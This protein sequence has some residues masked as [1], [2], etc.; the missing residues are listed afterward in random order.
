MGEA[1]RDLGWP[2]VGRNYCKFYIFFSFMI[3]FYLETI[4][5]SLALPN[6]SQKLE[7]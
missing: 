7:N 6:C 2:R 5:V 3:F 1:L 4:Y